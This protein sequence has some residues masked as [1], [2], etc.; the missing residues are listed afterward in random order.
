MLLDLRPKT[1]V[2]TNPAS[3]TFSS[4][5]VNG[6]YTATFKVKGYH[7]AENDY[8]SLTL[9]GAKDVFSINKTTIS[10]SVAEQGTE[11][12]VTYKPKA[13]GKKIATVTISGGGLTSSKTVQ[14]T[15]TAVKKGNNNGTSVV[16]RIDDIYEVSSDARISVDGLTIVIDSPVA[17][18]AIVSDISGHARSINLL[19]GRN[20]IPVNAGGLYIVR[21][22]QQSAKLMLR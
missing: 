4:K 19:A 17:Q 8:L 9:S 11:V 12:T 14:L 2:T 21:V 15:G 6:T 7:L 10:K 16:N 18:K 3:L 13:V 22:G 20:E 1:V 5:T